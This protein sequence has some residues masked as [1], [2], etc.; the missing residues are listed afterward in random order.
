MEKRKILIFSDSHGD[1]SRMERVLSMH[2]DADGV[3][4]LGD[5]VVRAAASCASRPLLF[6]GVKGNCDSGFFDF[7]GEAAEF[8]ERELVTVL[9]KRILLTHGHREG[10]KGGLGALIAEAKREGAYVAL[11]G[12]THRRYEEYIDHSHGQLWLFNPGSI[13][14]PDEG[15]ASFGLL[16]VTEKGVLLSHG[17]CP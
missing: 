14:R 9:G 17:E 5:G 15:R 2:P 1:E 8:R 3:F 10:V 11:F 7:F 16:T 4:F 12:H 13:S 6:V